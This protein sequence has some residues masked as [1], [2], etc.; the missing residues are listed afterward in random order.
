MNLKKFWENTV[1]YAWGSF[2]LRFAGVLLIPIY[3]HS[4]PMSQYGLLL[5]L[6]VT[7][8]VMRIF[9]GMQMTPAFIRFYKDYDSRELVGRLWGTSILLKLIGCFL[10]AG[11]SF[12]FLPPFF[13][14]MGYSFLCSRFCIFGRDLRIFVWNPQTGN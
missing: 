3:T 1:V 6:M 12:A 7:A 4:L 11:M 13:H 8:E 14:K 10:I 2:F 9:M 5:T